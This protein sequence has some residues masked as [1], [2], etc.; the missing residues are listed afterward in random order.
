[1]SNLGRTGKS[2]AGSQDPKLGGTCPG[3][4]HDA[5]RVFGTKLGDNF[6]SIEARSR[7]VNGEGGR[8]SAEDALVLVDHPR[9]LTRV[10]DLRV[11]ADVGVPQ[12]TSG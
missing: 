2:S 4:Y 12:G 9:A 3:G 1:L 6:V 10:I 11:P 7:N 8:Q 5:E